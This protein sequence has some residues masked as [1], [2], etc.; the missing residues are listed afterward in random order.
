MKP[1]KNRKRQ[2]RRK[3]NKL[4]HQKEGTL[5]P[6]RVRR[7]GKESEKRQ[8][9]AQRIW[10]RGIEESRQAAVAESSKDQKTSGPELRT[11]ARATLAKARSRLAD[12]INIADSCN[13][14]SHCALPE[15]PSQKELVNRVLVRKEIIKPSPTCHE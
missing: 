1:T 10:T 3:K 12:A 2:E 7:L 9:A 6:F 4:R 15:R 14:I 8:R 13:L 5:D 11:Q